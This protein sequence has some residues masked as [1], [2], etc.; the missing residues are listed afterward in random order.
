MGSTATIYNNGDIHWINEKEELHRED[1][2]AIERKDGTNIWYL[3]DKRHRIDGPA[4][5]VP[6]G[7][8][9]WINGEHHRE[10][11]PAIEWNANGPRSWWVNNELH[12]LDGPAVEY[13]SGEKSWYY[14]GKR[15]YFQSQEEFE[16]IIK[17]LPFE[18]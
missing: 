16:R 10:D 15:I 6:L 5:D 17:L 7:T 18:G 8:S 4:Y 11:G 13:V 1:G 2:P 3:N 12:R 14:H 9:W